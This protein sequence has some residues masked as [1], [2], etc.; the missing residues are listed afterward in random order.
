M[1]LEMMFNQISGHTGPVKLTHKINHYK[2]HL[3]S[4]VCLKFKWESA[5]KQ[6][7]LYGNFKYT[8]GGKRHHSGIFK[9]AYVRVTVPFH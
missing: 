8:G 4:T 3:Q 2:P 6:A 1:H 7:R 5:E 9:I